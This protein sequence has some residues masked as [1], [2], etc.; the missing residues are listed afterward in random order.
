MY[1]FDAVERA[2]ILYFSQNS[3]VARSVTEELLSITALVCRRTAQHRTLVM[4]IK[5]MK[6][7]KKVNWNKKLNKNETERKTSTKITSGKFIFVASLAAIK[8]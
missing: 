3:I 4:R 8:L 2:R 6:V 1:S 5:L 7:E